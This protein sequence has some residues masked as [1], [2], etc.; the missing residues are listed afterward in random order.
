MNIE[1]ITC[2]KRVGKRERETG[3]GWKDK[4]R[5]VKNCIQFMFFV[6]CFKRTVYFCF[7]DYRERIRSDALVIR[8]L[9]ERLNVVVN[10]SKDQ[11]AEIT[12][13]NRTIEC[14]YTCF[15]N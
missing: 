5:E 2:N 11:N 9:E 13:L 7:H 10:K 12:H 4:E 6:N 14:M 8:S 1:T 3:E 15:C